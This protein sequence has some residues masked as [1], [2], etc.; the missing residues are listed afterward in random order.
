ML[1]DIKF[2]Y[3]IISLDFNTPSVTKPLVDIPVLGK[4]MLEPPVF[5]FASVVYGFH[6]IIQMS[7]H[8]FLHTGV[9]KVAR[10]VHLQMS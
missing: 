7:W 4:E 9:K 3:L 8:K 5:G 2:E 6:P 1:R 10:Y